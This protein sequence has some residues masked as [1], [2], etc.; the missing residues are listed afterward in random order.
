MKAPRTGFN[1]ILPE[2]T[3]VQKNK[4]ATVVSAYYQMP[5]KY[6]NTEYKEWIRL[7]LENVP[8]HLVFYTEESLFP[9]ISECRRNFEDR[10]RIITLPRTEWVAN[11]KFNQTVWNNLH[12]QDPEATI[13]TPELYKIWFEKNEFVRR[14]IELNPYDHDDFVWVDAGICRTIPLANL[15]SNFPV[16]SRIPTNRIMLLNTMPFVARDDIP[17]KVNGQEFVG[18]VVSKPRIGG[19]IIA[20]SASS[21]QA[22]AQSFDTVLEKYKKAGI[23]WG[24]GQ[25]IMKTVVLENKSKISLIEVKAIAPEPWFYS[26]I[27]LGCSEN[28]W[29]VLRD[30]KRNDKKKSYVEL[31]ALT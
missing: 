14:T 10:T 18:G 9:F 11:K 4:P 20:G 6:P 30:E 24:K 23:F 2:G 25:D 28:L 3:F 8:C 22:Y 17:V 7:F 29:A 31:L 27:Y 1:Q 19:E 16:A 5:P 26:L 13:H 21:W 15:V 12:K